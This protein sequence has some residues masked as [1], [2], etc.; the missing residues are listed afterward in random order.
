M[1]T[2]TKKIAK[3]TFWEMTDAER[4]ADVKQFDKPTP[5]SQLRAMSTRER[6]RFERSRNGDGPS[7]SL[8]LGD[9]ETKIIIHLDEELLKQVKAYARTHKTTLPKMIDKGLRGLMSFGV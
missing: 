7:I 9:G 2:I 4:D 3:K 5:R 1:P 6:A 8:Y